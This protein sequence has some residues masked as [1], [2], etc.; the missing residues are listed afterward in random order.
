MNKNK[1]VWQKFYEKTLARKHH[2]RTERAVEEDKTGLH[3][4][5]DCGCGTGADMAYLA[6]A[7][8]QVSGFDVTLDAIDICKQ[9]FKGSTAI[10][11]TQASF[12]NY[13]YSQTSLII[14]NAS[15]FFA[16]S[17][18]FQQTWLKLISSLVSG[19]VFSGDFMGIKDDWSKEHT[20]PITS[21]TKSQ[22]IGL[23]EGF[24]II[25][26]H[27]RDEPGKTRIGTNKHWHTYSVIAVKA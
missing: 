24:N 23:F 5:I 6:R 8:Y 11:V 4:A 25:D 22:V 2:P 27:E 13:T 3:K 12:E 20:H 18:H 26:F 15:L 9:R 10:K 19:G 17:D 1:D 16:Q 14:A 7:G 21:L